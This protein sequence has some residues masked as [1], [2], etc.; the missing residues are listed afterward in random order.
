MRCANVCLGVIRMWS[1][2]KRVKGGSGKE[3]WWCFGRGKWWKY[4]YQGAVV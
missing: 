3:Y 1:S 2:A 4:R